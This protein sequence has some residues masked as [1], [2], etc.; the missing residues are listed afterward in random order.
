[1]LVWLTDAGL[2]LLERDRELL[3]P[4]LTQAALGRA[5]AGG[6]GHAG[7]HG[8]DAGVEGSPEGQI[9]VAIDERC[10]AARK[11]RHHD[12]KT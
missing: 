10:P 6:A 12:S 8:H 5:G 1:V 9:K 2:T 7:V 4:A 3:S 11:C